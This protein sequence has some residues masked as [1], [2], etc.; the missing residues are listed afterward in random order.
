MQNNQPV[1]AAAAPV[2]RKAKKG[3]KPAKKDQGGVAKAQPAANAAVQAGPVGVG[4]PPIRD[5]KYGVKCKD[6]AKGAC[7]FGHAGVVLQV[8]AKEGAVQPVVYVP[9]VEREYVCRGISD[10]LRRK[11]L[12][13]SPSDGDVVSW[14]KENG[15]PVFTPAA[16]SKT[17][18]PLSNACRVAAIRYM[19]GSICGDAATATVGSYFGAQKDEKICEI[20][21]FK[22]DDGTRFL[23]NWRIPGVGDAEETQAL[24]LEIITFPEQYF[25]GD[26]GRVSGR[27]MLGKAVKGIFLFD[28]Y[29]DGASNGP[30]T[31][32]TIRTLSAQTTSGIVY[33]GC[34]EF[35]GEAG[36]DSVDGYD[37]ATEMVWKRQ[38][39]GTIL[40]SPD[41]ADHQYHPHPDIPWLKNKT[42]QGLSIQYEKDFGPYRVFK[43]VVDGPLVVPTPARPI[44]R[45]I[46]IEKVEILRPGWTAMCL[47][48]IPKLRFNERFPER[49][50]WLSSKT[51]FL[52]NNAIVRKLTTQ[53]SSQVPT[54]TKWDGVINAV[55]SHAKEDE[56]MMALSARF[57][58]TYEKILRDTSL[59]VLYH[60]RRELAITARTLRRDHLDVEAALVE[61]RSPAVVRTPN[62]FPLKVCLSVLAICVIVVV[63]WNAIPKVHAQVDVPVVTPLSLW[64]YFVVLFTA[65]VPLALVVAKCRTPC[66]TM[67]PFFAEWLKARDEGW[68]LYARESCV[69]CLAQRDVVPGSV[70]TVLPSTIGRGTMSLYLDR[71]EV[72]LKE[73]AEIVGYE[74]TTDAMVTYIIIGTNG[75]LHRPAN[76]PMNL[77]AAITHRMH[78]PPKGERDPQK[79]WNAWNAEGDLLLTIF[80]GTFA[81]PSTIAECAASLGG[82]KEKMFL[83]NADDMEKGTYRSKK[84]SLTLR[85]TVMLK[86]NEHIPEKL[87]KSG[88]YYV[89]DVDYLE[90]TCIKPRAITVISGNGHVIFAP[91][92]R[93][94]YK[95]MHALFDGQYIFGFKTYFASGVTGEKLN[96]IGR[97]I[98]SGA[99]VIV[100][101]G[102]DSL[103]SV[104]GIV[105]F[106]DMSAFDQSQEEQCLAQH[107]R[108]LNA[109][110]VPPEVGLAHTNI[111][112]APYSARLKRDGLNVLG[113][114]KAQLP[115]GT[116]F[117][118]TFNSLSNLAF[119]FRAVRGSPVDR[120]SGLAFERAAYELSFEIK[121]NKTPSLFG[122]LFL[123]GWYLYDL[124][125][126]ICWF[127]LISQVVKIGKILRDPRSFSAHR[128][129]LEGLRIACRAA[130]LGMQTIPPEYPILGP[131]V[132]AMY[133]LGT[134]T[135]RVLGAEDGWYKPKMTSN[136][137]DRDFALA[138]IEH[139]YG[140]TVADVRR[141]EGLLSGLTTLPCFV[142]DPV[143][144]VLA[145]TDYA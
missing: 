63:V 60:N 102:D 33:V 144:D 73:F 19:V 119:C 57:G 26:A 108:V 83:K 29:F 31:P 100:V 133:R 125:G 15:Y 49:Y 58:L 101:A 140:I 25:P 66:Y 44:E 137:V 52:V 91:W 116:D 89:N 99:N 127:P 18:H 113:D 61:A 34:R 118:T 129:Y 97:A 67:R 50:L 5:C 103:I 9:P 4:K 55:L 37:G 35:V 76:V 40:A 134:D 22:G 72:T 23:T 42:Y 109:I 145:D 32:H 141:V 69:E 51:T 64:E 38:E 62:A 106:I 110:G 105:Y 56:V 122:A 17:P 20:V 92:S 104:D 82:A 95:I 68:R 107:V 2:G 79:R 143:F 111:C 80:A 128:N 30:I 114:A 13:V 12:H 98:S 87:V 21:P 11:P 131:F 10:F 120:K 6:L 14:L 88:A 36:A 65:M 117:T 121:M 90:D 27:S 86:N 41:E 16:R 43:I 46:P 138:Q 71:R 81:E 96:E 130:A 7:A 45:M 124:D 94:L 115:T 39:D 1:V 84:T 136:G 54:G 53:Y 74:H 112:A 24:D 78:T 123:R 28:V 135:S 93:A 75:M 8:A 85:K 126:E 3:R 139:R 132:A 77:V 142:V 70:C 59:Y 47:S 48:V